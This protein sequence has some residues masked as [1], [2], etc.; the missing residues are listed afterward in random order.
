MIGSRSSVDRC[1]RIACSAPSC[2]LRR[3]RPELDSSTNRKRLESASSTTCASFGS[4]ACEPGPSLSQHNSPPSTARR[5]MTVKT[6]ALGPHRCWRTSIYS[7]RSRRPGGEGGERER[8]RGGP[9]FRRRER[10]PAGRAL[11]R[12]SCALA[13]ADDLSVATPTHGVT[14]SGLSTWINGPLCWTAR[15]HWPQAAGRVPHRPWSRRGHGV[16]A[17]SDEIHASCTARYCRGN[18]VAIGRRGSDRADGAL[19]SERLGHPV[20]RTI[21]RRTVVFRSTSPNF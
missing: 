14:G 2:G 15:P 12:G 6:P 16:S 18:L 19:L 20:R 21:G 5:S 4:C 10:R 17:S 1:A 8:E 11:G 3:P 13:T 7:H 9:I